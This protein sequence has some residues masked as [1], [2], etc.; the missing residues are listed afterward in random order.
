ML[1]VFVHLDHLDL[2]LVLAGRAAAS[3]VVR[4]PAE[5]GPL[6]GLHDPDGLVA[7][8]LARG[9]CCSG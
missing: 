3:L 2:G 5:R 7:A 6:H 9:F 4:S 8:L 1:Y